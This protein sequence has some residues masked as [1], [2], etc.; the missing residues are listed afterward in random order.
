MQ[1]AERGEK[2]VGGEVVFIVQLLGCIF[3]C[4][5]YIAFLHGFYFLHLGENAKSTDLIYLLGS[6]TRNVGCNRVNDGE[7]D[8]VSQSTLNALKE[9]ELDYRKLFDDK[10]FLLVAS[11]IK[12]GMKET[13]VLNVH[14]CFHQ[15]LVFA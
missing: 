11:A 4:F 10:M 3:C 15:Y 2:G 7:S 9:A 5:I 1:P 8:L 14:Y 12:E 6:Y 13:N